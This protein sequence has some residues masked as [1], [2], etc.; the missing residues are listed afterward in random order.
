ML[1]CLNLLLLLVADHLFHRLSLQLIGA[2][3]NLN[4]FFVLR[5]LLLET[6][7]FKEVLLGL[8]HH[9]VSNL[10]SLLLALKTVTFLS[11]TLF[12]VALGLESRLLLLLLLV[13]NAHLHDVAGLLLSLFNL[14]P[15][16]NT[17]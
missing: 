13:P 14:L 10:L 6:L 5:F 3:L 11:F 2:L 16:L 7:R 15:C 17:Q 12:S 9:V 4:H 8:R 1:T